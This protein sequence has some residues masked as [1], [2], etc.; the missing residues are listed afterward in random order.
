MYDMLIVVEAKSSAA[1]L[2][3]AIYIE[4]TRGRDEATKTTMEFAARC[5][6]KHIM[7]S[8]SVC[9]NVP[10]HSIPIVS[11]MLRILRLVDTLMM[12]GGGGAGKMGIGRSIEC[13]LA[14][15][16]RALSLPPPPPS[17]PSTMLLPSGDDGVWMGRVDEVQ[18][19]RRRW[20]R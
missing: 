19:V 8:N 12:S 3:Q 11:F 4:A 14:V 5:V 18:K 6:F 16:C 9:E 13:V 20:G 15:D 1:T 10:K 2:V 17:L 7:S